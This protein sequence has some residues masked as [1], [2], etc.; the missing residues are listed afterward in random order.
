[1]RVRFTPEALRAIREKREWWSLHREKAPQLLLAELTTVIT[2]LRRGAD[3]ERHLFGV[4]GGRQVWRLL[5]PR[6]KLHVYYRR[7]D[8][9]D[10]E[11]LVVWNATAGAPPRILR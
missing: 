10:V 1:M 9:G 3:H 6:T 2:K 7:D 5:M 11:V 8:A 4:R